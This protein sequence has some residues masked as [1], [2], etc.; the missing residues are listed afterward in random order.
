MEISKERLG[1]EG[2]N[3]NYSLNIQEHVFSNLYLEYV[4]IREIL[5]TL[6]KIAIYYDRAVRSTSYL[7]MLEMLT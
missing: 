2:I 4:I 5:K 1:Y 7:L 3:N 6:L